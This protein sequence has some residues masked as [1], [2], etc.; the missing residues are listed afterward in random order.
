MAKSAGPNPCKEN[1][2]QHEGVCVPDYSLQDYKCTCK[3]GYTGKDCQRDINECTGSHGCH[4]THGYCVNTVG[5]Y[6]C[7]CRSGYVGDGRSCTVRECV[8][9]NTLTERSRNI[10]YG[11]VGSKCDDT[12]I[13]RA[14]DWYRFTGSAGSRM[15]D[16]CPTTKC[17]TAFQGWLS[18][19]QPGYGQVKVSRALCWQGNNICCNWPST[20]R[21]THCISFI[22]YEL[23]PVSGCH[24]R[25][26]GF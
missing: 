17:D 4:P 6:N 22:V 2:C 16:R 19:G 14:G 7:Y 11:L 8:H 3:P 23:K 20:I 9:Y 18:G 10:N 21:V 15:L 12:G 13:L 24:L 1:P 25:Y 26:C 5:S